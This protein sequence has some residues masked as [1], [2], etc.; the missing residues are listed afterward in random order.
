MPAKLTN[1]G[2][3][4]LNLHREHVCHKT[5]TSPPVQVYLCKHVPVQCQQQ[6]HYII[7]W[8]MFKVN[9]DNTRTSSFRSLWSLSCKLCIYFT[10]FS[11]V[12]VVDFEHEFV[13]LG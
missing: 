6:K 8:N 7:V 9:N 12:H 4:F 10:P 13:Y 5:E 11:S 2:G 3:S 1:T